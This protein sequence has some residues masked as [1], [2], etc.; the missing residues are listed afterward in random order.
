MSYHEGSPWKEPQRTTRT[1]RRVV[2]GGGLALALFII[3][4]VMEIRAAVIVVALAL[5]TAL[6]LLVG[7]TVSKHRHP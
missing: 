7:S 6:V 2:L 3:L 5:F 1:R 4:A